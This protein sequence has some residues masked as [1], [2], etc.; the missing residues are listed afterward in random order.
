MGLRIFQNLLK[1]KFWWNFTDGNISNILGIRS[2]VRSKFHWQVSQKNS[3]ATDSQ[4]EKNN[5]D[6]QSKSNLGIK[7]DRVNYTI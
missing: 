3:W 5:T 6:Y 2:A 1:V 4:D 7:Q